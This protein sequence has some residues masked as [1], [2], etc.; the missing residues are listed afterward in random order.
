MG[1]DL[2]FFKSEILLF[3]NMGICL[4]APGILR[5]SLSFTAHGDSNQS[6]SD[7]EMSKSPVWTKLS[8]VPMQLMTLVE[9]SHVASGVGNSLILT[10]RVK[11]NHKSVS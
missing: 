1:N 2:S 3:G 7:V 4:L 11:K 6:E 9:L 10:R 8:N 5:I